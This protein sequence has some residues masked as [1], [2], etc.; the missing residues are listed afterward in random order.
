MKFKKIQ[1]KKIQGLLVIGFLGLWGGILNKA[2]RTWPRLWGNDL[3][4]SIRTF[5]ILALLG[6][7]YSLKM[8]WGPFFSLALPSWIP[9]NP[10]RFWL[11]MHLIIFSFLLFVIS[12]CEMFSGITFFLC[13]ALLFMLDGNYSMLVI[14]CQKDT[15]FEKLRG[16]PESF[17]LN[18]YRAGM[19]FAV[20]GALFCS[21]QAW[22]WPF[23]YHCLA[24]GCV[25][26]ALSILF[27]P[28]FN[29]LDLAPTQKFKGISYN[30]FAPI[31]ELL[32]RPQIRKIFLI[33]MLY[34]IGD[35]LWTP[36]QELF[37]LHMG[38]SKQQYS[39]QDFWNFW[40]SSF[41][42]FF[43]GYCIQKFSVFRVMQWGL[44]GQMLVFGGLFLGSLSSSLS[45]L[46]F[47]C[48]L[49]R[50]LLNFSLTS[51]FAFQIMTVNLGQAITQLSIFTALA[52]LN[53]QLVS[54]CSGWLVVHLGWSG[55]IFFS[56][57]GCIPALLYMLYVKK[58][59]NFLL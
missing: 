56:M 47:L 43:S 44:S 52:H 19:T 17:C 42:I 36:N 27:L 59:K 28:I 57:L 34:R 31:K 7:C 39:M 51:V 55:M 22:S 3:G 54:S 18:G 37:F 33:L 30:F 50:V 6:I 23:L 32:T 14:A 46:S 26:I 40:G 15:G 2:V 58:D 49:Q 10:R 35:H 45:V 13:T 24:I 38:F 1:E 9:F 12:F 29:S 11:S 41:G 48:I 25:I 53:S 20:S 5:D 16:L 4:V 21:Q 8:L